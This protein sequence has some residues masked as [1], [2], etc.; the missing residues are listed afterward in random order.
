MFTN[1]QAPIGTLNEGEIITAEIDGIHLYH[2]A[3]INLGTQ[4]HG[5]IPVN[6]EQWPDVL[7]LLELDT[8]V[9]VRV[10]KACPSYDS[11][12]QTY[13]MHTHVSRY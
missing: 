12:I 8:E 1:A 11:Y 6:E 13:C 4:Y 2:G 10:Y 5:V 7:D 3:V 9:K